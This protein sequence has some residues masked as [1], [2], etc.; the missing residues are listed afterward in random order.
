M[1]S[2]RFQL[3]RQAASL[4]AAAAALVNACGGIEPAAKLTRVSASQLQRY[5]ADSEPD[6][7]MP[8]DVVRALELHCGDPIVTRFLAFENSQLLVPFEP[9]KSAGLMAH[10]GAI[11]RDTGKMYAEAC[12][13][14]ADGTLTAREAEK[15]MREGY[16]LVTTVSA[17]VADLRA[18]VIGGKRG[19]R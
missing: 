7:Q 18:V 19:G 9:G 5:T 11:G 10:L 6:Y 1:S 17:L 8:V 3:P 4:K 14:L 13:G 2:P 12:Q 16:S 15:V